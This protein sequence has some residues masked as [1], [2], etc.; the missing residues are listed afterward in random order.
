MEPLTIALGLA[1]LT[2]LDKK[3]GRWIGGDNGEEVAEKVVSIA[4]QVTGAKNG[5]QA[6]AKLE[7]NPE[8]LI[9]FEQAMHEHELHLEEL[10]YKDRA[11]A[12]AMQVAALQGNDTLSKRFVYYFAIGW[13]LFAFLYLGFITFGD[14]PEANIRFADTVLGFLLGTVLAGMFGFFYG[15]SAGNERRAEQQ[16]L[17]TALTQR[18]R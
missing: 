4:Q 18:R 13:S 14:I 8:Q 3:I 2:G 6:L 17:H 7:A 9:E 5:D 16:D 11:D 1:K 15:S 10:A 12:R